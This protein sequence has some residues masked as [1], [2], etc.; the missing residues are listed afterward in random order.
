MCCRLICARR[1]KAEKPFYFLFVRDARRPE[2]L[3]TFFLCAMREWPNY[4]LLSASGVE[5]IVYGSKLANA[6]EHL[7]KGS[8]RENLTKRFLDAVKVECPEKEWIT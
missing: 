3:S 8:K 7:R 4:F 6:D 2:N 1:K 5:R